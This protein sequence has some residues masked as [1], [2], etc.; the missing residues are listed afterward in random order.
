MK[1]ILRALAPDAFVVLSPASEIL[2]EG[3]HG[4]DVTIPLKDLK[5]RT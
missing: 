2:G 4:V 3:F 5:N 1:D